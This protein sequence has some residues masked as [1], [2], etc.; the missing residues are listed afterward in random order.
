M[1][2]EV[3]TKKAPQ[4]IGP[5]SQAV[6]CGNLI[7]CSGNIGVDPKTGTMTAGGIKEQT[8]QVFQ[9]LKE[10]L[11]EAGADFHSVVKTTV[12]LQNMSDFSVMN[13][14][15]GTYFKKPY[16]ARATIEVSKLPKD[17]L[18]EIECTAYLEKVGCGCQCL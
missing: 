9:N 10:V 8:R 6:K 2:Q 11:N 13:E 18:I 4:A 5:Y 15:Y 1:I 17:A 14:I 16:P 3:N 12:Y 7:F